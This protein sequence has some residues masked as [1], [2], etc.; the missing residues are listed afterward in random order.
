MEKLKKVLGTISAVVMAI[1]GILVLIFKRK[2]DKAEVDAK[3]AETKAKDQALAEQ[4]EDVK[5]AIASLDAGLDKMKAEQEAEARKRKED[6]MTLK[7]RAD[8]IRKGL[9]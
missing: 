7:E 6:N 8:R 4:Q 1:L 9:K 3:L 2:S 5:A